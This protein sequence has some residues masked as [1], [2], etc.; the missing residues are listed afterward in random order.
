MRVI[1][2][3]IEV[4]RICGRAVTDKA[5]AK[6]SNCTLKAMRQRLSEVLAKVED[7]M[8]RRMVRKEER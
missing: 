1:E 8:D 3:S 2:P 4:D 5:V 6:Y 7:E